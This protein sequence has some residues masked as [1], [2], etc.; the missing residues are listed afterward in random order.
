[1][2]RYRVAAKT[3]DQNKNEQ[4]N[5][6]RDAQQP[7]ASTAESPTSPSLLLSNASARA[8][9]VVSSAAVAETPTPPPPR[10]TVATSTSSAS[11]ESAA[12][13]S[14]ARSDDYAYSKASTFSDWHAQKVALADTQLPQPTHVETSANTS[15][16]GGT[17]YLARFNIQTLCLIGALLPGIGCYGALTRLQF[18]AT[19]AVFAILCLFVVSR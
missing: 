4:T 13:S 3:M 17:K 19:S 18:V 7:T 9:A 12:D 2:T 16:I 10:V 1:M 8:V 6:E 5:A 11:L 15:S 14:P